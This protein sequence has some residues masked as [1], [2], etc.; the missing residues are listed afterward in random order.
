MLQEALAKTVALTG[1]FEFREG[2]FFELEFADKKEIVRML[3]KSKTT[4]WE[5]HQKVDRFDD[6]V[7]AGLVAVKVKNWHG[8]TW[9]TLSR[10]HNIDVSG[11]NL[12]EPIPYHADDAAALCKTV[13]GLAN[14]VRE[15][16]MNVAGFRDAAQEI[17]RK[18]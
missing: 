13:Y 4:A 16:I 2:I 7:F 12:N 1:W 5:K 8:L 18:N 10:I 9:Q 17:E 6:E 11:K 14:W 3:E 15:T